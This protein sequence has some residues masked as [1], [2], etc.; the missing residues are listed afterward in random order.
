MLEIAR[1]LPDPAAA[2]SGGVG[3]V[4]GVGAGRAVGQ[5]P[6]GVCRAGQVTL[7]GCGGIGVKQC[8]RL[9]RGG[10]QQAITQAHAG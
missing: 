3:G 5:R 6:A 4:G 10:K 8:H 1:Q 2:P 9:G 7:H